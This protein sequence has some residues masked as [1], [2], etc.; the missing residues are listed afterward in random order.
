MNNECLLAF[1]A[2]AK[3]HEK[4]LGSEH[5]VYCEGCAALLHRASM[6]VLGQSLQE[7]YLLVSQPSVPWGCRYPW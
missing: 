1:R 3:F 4:M 7:C 2:W 5:S 6:R